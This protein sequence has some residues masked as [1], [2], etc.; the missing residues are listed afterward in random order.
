[1]CTMDRWYLAMAWTYN[2]SQREVNN[3]AEECRN[4]LILSYP[5]WLQAGHIPGQYESLEILTEVLV[6]EVGAGEG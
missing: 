4:E 3:L 2:S 1:M 5:A 6:L